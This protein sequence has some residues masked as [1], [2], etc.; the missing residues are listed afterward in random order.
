MPMR[1]LLYQTTD[2]FRIE[3]KRQH[4]KVLAFTCKD[5]KCINVSFKDLFIPNTTELFVK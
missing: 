4:T 3:C 2:N 5:L 1:Q